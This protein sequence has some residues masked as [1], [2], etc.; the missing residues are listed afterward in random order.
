MPSVD[1][2]PRKLEAPRF[3]ERRA[4]R[5][6]AKPPTVRSATATIVS[7]TAFTV[8]LSAV[9]MRVID[10]EEYPNIWRALWWAIQTIPTVG[11]GDVTPANA[12]GRIVAAAV[13]LEAIAFLA[14]VTAAV[15]SVFIERARL[16]VSPQRTDELIERLEEIAARLERLENAMPHPPDGQTTVDSPGASTRTS[17]PGA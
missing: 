14:V 8:V 1:A 7:L 9:L 6:L 16:E 17:T 15:T 2:E 4:R 11:Y 12:S 10:S 5:F 3:V 13:M